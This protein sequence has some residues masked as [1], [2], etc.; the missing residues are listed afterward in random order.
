MNATLLTTKL[1]V[2]SPRPDLVPRPRLIERLDEGLRRGRKLTLVSAP[3]GFG[4]TTL[5]SAWV[6]TVDRPVGWVSLDE[7]DSDPARLWTYFVAAL[8]TALPGVG[9]A[10]LEALRSPQPSTIEPVLTSLINEIAATATPCVLV[11]DDFHMITN[12]RVNDAVALLL[13]RMPP[14]LHLVISARADPPWPLARMRARGDLTEVRADDLRFTE[15][16]AAAFLNDAMR[17]GLSVEEVAALGAR[18]E[19]WI[20]GLQMAA[21]SMRGRDDAAAFI[22]AFSGSHRF[23]LDYLVEEVLDRQPG[24]VQEF[25]LQTSVLERMTGPLCDAVT[26][27]ED[28]QAVL[29]ALDRANLF[30]VA[31][32]DERRW[33]RY[34]R[35]FTDLL[36]SR[37]QHDVPTRV[38]ELHRAASRW[39]E[40]EGLVE[41]AVAHALAGQDL[42]HAARLIERSAMAMIAQSKV[43]TLSRW[44]EALPIETV[45]ARAGL[46]VYHAWAR[47]WTGL[48]EQGEQCLQDARRALASESGQADQAEDERRLIAG[49]VAA[50]RSFYALTYEEIPHVL[51]AAQE[52]VELLPEGDYMRIMAVLALGGAHWGHGDVAAAERAFTEA[53][54]AARRSGYRFLAVS[55]KCY[56]GTHQAKQGRL[57]E[58]WQTFQAA[59]ELATGASGRQLPAAGL[60]SVKLGAL[61]REWND[62]VAADR[63]TSRGVELC[64][65]WGQADSLVETYVSLGRLRLAQGDLQAATDAL[66]KAGQIA[67]TTKIDPWVSCW[68]DDCRLRLWLSSGDLVTA[69]RWAEASGLRPDGELSF[70]HDLNH[71]NL[72]RVLVAQSTRGPS[73]LFLGQALGLLTR[74]LTAAEGA[75]WVSETIHILTLQALA[76]RASGEHAAA[77]ATLERALHLAEPEGY[78]RAFLD[79]GEPMTE[80]LRQAAAQGIMA[81][82]VGRLLAATVGE[83]GD[84]RGMRVS[85]APAL[86][87]PLTG[88]ELEVLRLLPSSL[89]STEIAAHLIISVHTAR[90][91][92][93][94]IYGKLDVHSRLEAVQRA[95]GLGLL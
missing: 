90:T 33:Y 36:R 70:L 69:A 53:S 21:L 39:F 2:P 13:G 78:V 9:E 86:V 14:Q 81:G 59:H 5:L 18:A 89:S 67:E 85:P 52:A 31:L 74:L 15:V 38:A 60:P 68:L 24:H 19:G 75:G 71:V 8:Q 35:L 77:L 45:R 47:Y 83:P 72:A 10:A 28:G 12:P 73:E 43:V 3:A 6:A 30:L 58:A 56:A 34:H 32:D 17:L 80:L 37:L 82:Y 49:R 29:T 92:I 11:V 22:R 20:T 26:G 91:H 65:Q 88:R 93:K 95:R 44:L 84:R 42:E 61:A 51:Q 54:A 41:D 76:L 7:G 57:R 66:R 79:E 40:R 94:S 46:C 48:R 87:E 50:I 63:D 62:L 4:K 64:V 27:R 55:A 23:V 1:H 16:E 25:L